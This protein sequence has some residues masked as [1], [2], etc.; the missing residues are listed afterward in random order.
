MGLKLQ[1]VRSW[2]DKKTGR[3]YA[4]FRYRGVDE[5]LPSPDDPAFG[6]EYPRLL[7]LYTQA[8]PKGQ[9]AEA[10]TIKWLVGQYRQSPEYNQLASRTRT[11]YD[12][13]FFKIIDR[14][15]HQPY[16]QARRSDIIRHIR[17]PLSRTPRRADYAVT[18]LSVLYSWAVSRDFVKENPCIGVPKLHKKTEGYRA[19]A[20]NE[21]KRFLDV[22]D[23]W[24]WLVFCLGLYTAQRPG[25][26][27]KLTWF[28]Y[29]GVLFTIRQSKTAHRMTIDVHPTLKA[30]LDALPRT[31]GA[32]ITRPDGAAYQTSTSLARRWSK[33]MEKH[34]LLGCTVHGLR[35]TTPTVL[36]ELGASEAQ[37]KSVTG[38][39]T[40]AMVRHY[41]Q[42]ADQKR[43]NRSAVAMLPAL[44]RGK[45]P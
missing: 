45:R 31:D 34:G 43:L 44:S 24:E 9:G 37:L 33:G 41:T 39:V 18:V 28:Q 25:D 8:M 19:W 12:N 30:T 40:A 42:S 22:C 38:H 1:Y 29:D 36:A 7:R 20:A 27:I 14:A 4:R 17:D 32:I 35:K 13:L 23:D 26:L 6:E 5:P 10:G 2:I 3:T 21:I 15:G 11:D 16:R